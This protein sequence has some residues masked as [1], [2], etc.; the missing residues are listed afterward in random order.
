MSENNI[1]INLPI[2]GLDKLSNNPMPT[3]S[4]FFNPIPE[5]EID[6]EFGDF[7]GP[8]VTQS[9]DLSLVV[10]PSLNSDSNLT[11]KEY[12]ATE[13]SVK[14]SY[15]P[16]YDIDLERDLTA[17]PQLSWTSLGNTDE[18]TDDEFTNFT[19]A[20][21]V[22]SDLLSSDFPTT[23]S[24]TILSPNIPD[25]LSSQPTTEED[26]FSVQDQ[27]NLPSL[28]AAIVTDPQVDDDFGDFTQAVVSPPVVAEDLFS[29]NTGLNEQPAILPD[30]TLDSTASAAAPYD[31]FK[32]VE[33][34]DVTSEKSIE[35]PHVDWDEPLKSIDISEL[36]RL[37]CETIKPDEDIDEAPQ[38]QNESN[39]DCLLDEIPEVKLDSEPNMEVAPSTENEPAFDAFAQEDT[40]E[41]GDFTDFQVAS[42]PAEMASEDD[43][44]F[45]DFEAAP[46]SSSAPT[47]ECPPVESATTTPENQIHRVLMT[48][49]PVNTPN[50]E[51]QT[52]IPQTT[53]PGG[54]LWSYISQLDS[55]PALSFSWRHSAA[56]QRFLHSLRIDTVLPVITYTIGYSSTVF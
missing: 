55:T 50:V 52:A 14:P 48:L 38:I 26:L 11:T 25:L 53:S 45:D 20:E 19:S 39:E 27:D 31:C 30:F 49:F 34:V 6:E 22:H 47:L 43:D 28:Q 18:H 56:Q 40:D 44:E 8:I 12:P 1:Q 21:P 13:D 33:E 2:C 41:F 5:S 29:L 17:V 9:A 24:N 36:P 15:K 16:N 4:V 54:T 46:P 10:P 35:T 32:E 3:N 37:P 23:E 51:Q 42:E 7:C